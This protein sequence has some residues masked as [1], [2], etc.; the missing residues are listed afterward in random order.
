[1]QFADSVED[2]AQ[3]RAGLRIGKSVRPSAT[4]LLSTAILFART[5]RA[6]KVWLTLFQ[7]GHTSRYGNHGAVSAG[8]A[9]SRVASPK[10]RS[11]GG[12]RQVGS[13]RRDKCLFG[14]QFC[15]NARDLMTPV[16]DDLTRARDELSE[17]PGE[18]LGPERGI[19]DCAAG[20]PASHYFAPLDSIRVIDSHHGELIPS[21]ALVGASGGAAIAGPTQ[22]GLVEPSS[23]SATRARCR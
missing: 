5:I 7:Y 16:V 21:H 3:S 10:Q 23:R 18:L 8:P 1:M 2:P 12:N 20:A 4:A 15:V 17:V 13:S 11:V 19:H 22:R 9:S 14:P 6:G